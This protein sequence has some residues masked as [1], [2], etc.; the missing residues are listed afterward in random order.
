[1][2]TP[3]IGMFTLAH[4]RLAGGSETRDCL[5]EVGST[6]FQKAC[7]DWVKRNGSHHYRETNSQYRLLV[8][9]S[10]SMRRHDES[11]KGR[12]SR[13]SVAS[14]SPHSPYVDGPLLARCFA[15]L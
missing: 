8:S 7:H 6:F 2:L 11:C 9:Q 15:V 4:S 5:R 10:R 14:V 12:L 13:E 1:D 3:L